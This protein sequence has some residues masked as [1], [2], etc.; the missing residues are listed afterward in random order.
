MPQP[1]SAADLNLLFGI[2]ALHMDFVSRDQL[3]A[4]MHAWVLDKSKSLGA[5]LVE[6]NVLGPER[7]SL[8]QALVQEHLKQHH[9]DPQR[10]LA[11]VSSIGSV[12]KDLEQ[13]ADA[14]VQASLVRVAT[15]EKDD[16]PFATVAPSVGTPTSSGLR[17]RILRSHARGGLGEVFVAHDEEVHRQVALKRIQDRHADDPESRSRFLLEAEI[18][19]GLEHPGIVPV[20]GLGHYS[21]GRPFYAMRF[22]RGDSLGD[23]IQRFHHP[24]PGVLPS[25]GVAKPPEGGTTNPGFQSREF[26]KLLGRFIDVCEAIQ[27][28]HARGVLHRD[29]KPGNIMLGK[30]GE[31]L[32]V[33]WGLAKA[34]GTASRAASA[35]GLRPGE[36]ASLTGEPPLQPQSGTG[37]SATRLGSALGTPAYMSPEQAAGRFDLLGSASDVYSLGATLFHLLTGRPPREETDAALV[38]AKVQAGDFPRPGQVMPDVDRALEAICLKAMALAPKDRYA[39]PRDLADDLEQW[40]AD[41]PVSAWPEPWTVKARRWVGGHRTLV[42]G[43]AAA[44]LVGLVSLAILVLVLGSKYEAEKNFKLKLGEANDAE[45]KT[46]E[47]LK[48]ANIDLAE[49]NKNLETARKNEL[50]KA[51]A[52]QKANEQT[53][54]AFALN[55]ALLAQSRWNE[56]NVLLANDLLEQVPRQYRYGGWHFLKRQ[57]QGSYCTLYGHL[58]AVTS[59]AFSPDQKR[60]ASASDDGTVKLWDART[61]VELLTFTGHAGGVASV[62]FNHDGKRVVSAS[63]ETVKLWDAGTGEEILSLAHTHRVKR[64]TLT[65]SPEAQRLATADSHNVIRVWDA[66]TGAEIGEYYALLD[67]VSVSFSP[68]G[69]RL[70]C[71]TTRGTVSVLEISS[72]TYHQCVLNLRHSFVN[73]VSSVS[74]S[75]DGAG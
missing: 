21:D 15:A 33:D 8:L 63:A 24:H 35:A 3:I 66:R 50:A 43:T 74:F 61:G 7:H 49:T 32:V 38:M 28:A 6:Q 26:R 55:T 17:F 46:N 57:F 9:N 30:Y 2:L 34:T 1:A 56:G 53:A 23:A 12:K 44:L 72:N 10:S 27:Y 59:I 16:D 65:F 18:T 45:K 36:P 41:K 58:K 60:I 42:T 22:I 67:V 71:A 14:D 37:G 11:A 13:V 47:K 75:P 48:N 73:G 62:S 64:M 54:A 31:T 39:S 4:A 51:D 20:Y 29:L 68:D 70:A 25:R 40:L 69:R 19:G 5:I 52:E